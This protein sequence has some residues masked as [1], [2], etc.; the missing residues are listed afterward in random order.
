MVKG[1]ALPRLGQFRQYAGC[2]R[3]PGADGG[4]RPGA[5]RVLL[6]PDGYC[7]LHEHGRRRVQRALSRRGV[8]GLGRSCGRQQI[9]QASRRVHVKRR[10]HAQDVRRGRPA[11]RAKLGR[12]AR[13]G[14]ASP[15]EDRRASV[16]SELHQADQ[17]ISRRLS[18]R[19]DWS[20]RDLQADPREEPLQPL[21]CRRD[22]SR[23]S[24]RSGPDPRALHWRPGNDAG[25][26]PPHIRHHEQPVQRPGQADILRRPEA[27]LYS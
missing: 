1:P 15:G 3:V 10:A 23:D 24:S 20:H 5:Q 22:A 13:D 18:L 16:R 8:P 26:R 7:G 2:R 9:F 11:E 17:R 19:G 4:T 12:Q 14:R 6:R 25:G 21:L 27:G